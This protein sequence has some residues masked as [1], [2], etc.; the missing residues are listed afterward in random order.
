MN[1][2]WR[3][4]YGLWLDDESFRRIELEEDNILLSAREV[5]KNGR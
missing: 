1:K 2:K 5:L 4:D 3:E